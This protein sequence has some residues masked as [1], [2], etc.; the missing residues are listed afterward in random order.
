MAILN[1]AIRGAQ[2]EDATISGVHLLSTNSPT[3]GYV[4]KWNGTEEKFEWG[5]LGNMEANEIPFG[6]INGANVTYTLSNT[7]ASG[8][9]M[10]FL[11]G[12]LQQ[13]GAGNDY[14]IAGDTITMVTAPLTD[15]ILLSTYLTE[16]GL[17]GGSGLENVVEDTTP[18][19]GGDLDLNEFYIGLKPA[20]SSDDAGSGLMSS[21]TVDTN[22]VGVG[23]ALFMAAD[24]NYDEADADAAAT[25]PCTVLA[26]E[27]G[28]GTKKVLHYGYM[29][30]DDWNWTPG[31]LLY[32]S[33]TAGTLTA[34]AP[35]GS[36][37]QVQVVGYATHADRIFF[38]PNLAMA[39]V[40]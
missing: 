1:T 3:D 14:T 8:T 33:D 38:S 25:M 7:P 36:G 19:L 35:A 11:N 9:V 26:L 24:G 6:D 40:A 10:L 27:T 13:E 4:L 12:L 32:V 2:I 22:G 30:N 39:E 23:A 16:Q 34:T 29:R 20:P 5:T 28:T 17:G 31:A 18:Q 21:V 15:D 37:D